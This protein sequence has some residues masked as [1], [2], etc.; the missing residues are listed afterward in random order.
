MQSEA[1]AARE[2]V[3]QAEGRAAAAAEAREAAERGRQESERQRRQA[4]VQASTAASLMQAERQQRA[5]AQGLRY[6]DLVLLSVRLGLVD[7]FL[8]FFLADLALQFFPQAL[9]VRGHQLDQPHLVVQFGQLAIGS[10]D[11]S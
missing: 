8:P 7:Q 2:R 3:R 4:E 5:E 6:A 10:L 11:V 1:E 9:V